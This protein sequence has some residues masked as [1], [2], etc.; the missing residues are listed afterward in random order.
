MFVLFVEKWKSEE[1]KSEASE[2]V[3]K[4]P[5]SGET[6]ASQLQVK[7]AWMVKLLTACAVR[8]GHLFN[9]HSF[10]KMLQHLLVLKIEGISCV[11]SSFAFVLVSLMLTCCNQSQLTFSIRG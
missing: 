4:V 11:R 3:Y 8:F 10:H 1:Y 5:P 9:V 2:R 7:A 6:P